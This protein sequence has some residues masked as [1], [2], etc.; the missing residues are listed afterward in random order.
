MPYGAGS[1]IMSYV[2]RKY[3]TPPD[4]RSRWAARKRDTSMRLMAVVA[5]S[6]SRFPAITARPSSRHWHNTCRLML[7]APSVANCSETSK[8]EL[9]SPVGAQ[10]TS[11]ESEADDALGMGLSWVIAGAVSPV[12]D[13]AGNPPGAPG[14][15]NVTAVPGVRL[16]NVSAARE[17]VF[18]P[19]SARG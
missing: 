18:P 15:W 3:S 10:V 19:R 9:S 7:V 6:D 2:A 14:I 5:H 4:P 1:G 11:T 16:T 17:T 13:A 8:R 12:K